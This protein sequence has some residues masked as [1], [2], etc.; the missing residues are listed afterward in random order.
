M[1]ALEY[2]ISHEDILKDLWVLK[3]S[4][5]NIQNRLRIANDS[6]IENIKTWMVR[7]PPDVFEK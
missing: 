3:Y 4:I 7:A 5:E 2:G 6:H 1:F